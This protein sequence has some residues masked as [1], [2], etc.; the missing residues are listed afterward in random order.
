MILDVSWMM[1]LA[2]MT[3]FDFYCINKVTNFQIES[4]HETLYMQNMILPCYLSTHKI[5]DFSMSNWKVLIYVWNLFFLKQQTRHYKT[6]QN[7][8]WPSY[9]FQ[10]VISHSYS[11]V[12][13]I[14]TKYFISNF[15]SYLDVEDCELT[16]KTLLANQASWLIM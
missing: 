7:S 15:N 13:Q 10:D 12:S 1:N 5:I 9:K 16:R 8:L 14:S 11:I 2:G 6:T 4:S 3:Y